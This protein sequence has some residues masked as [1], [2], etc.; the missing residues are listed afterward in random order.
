MQKRLQARARAVNIWLMAPLLGFAVFLAVFM[1]AMAPV[2]AASS[3]Y[4]NFQAR[5]LGSNGTIVPD[6]TYNIDFKLYNADSTTGTVGTCSGTC[7]W[8]ETRKNSNSQ[9]VQVINGY[10][11]VNLGSVTAFPS[12]INWDQQLWLTMNIGGTSTGASPT[13]DGEMQN[14]GHSILLTAI[15]YSFIAGQLAKTSGANRGTLAF[16]TV[17]NN[18][19]ILLPDASGTVCLQSASACGFESTT[20]TDFIRNQVTVQTANFNI[21]GTGIIGTAL[22]TGLIKTA[23]SSTASTNDITLR[24]GNQTGSSLSSGN[25]TIKSGDASGGTNSSS[26]N[27]TID[28]GAK[29]G[30][31]TTGTISIGASNASGITIGNISL[32]NT[33]AIDASTISIGNSTSTHTINIGHGGTS[34]Q[35]INIGSTSSGSGVSI[36][37]GT[38]GISLSGNTAVSGNLDVSGSFA[39]KK[40]AADY[41]T[42]GPQ[43]DVSFGNASLVRLT[44][45]ST[46]TI[47]GIANGRDG[48]LLNLV[49]AA[50]QTAIIKN[51]DTT[52]SAAANVV[53]TG[54]G[55]DYNLLAG[56]STQLVYDAG[57]NVWRMVGAAVG[58]TGLGTYSSS[59]HYAN[60]AQISGNTLT[61]GSADG[62]N[63]GL[64]DTSNQTFAGN[65][66]FSGTLTVA[67][68]TNITSAVIKQTSAASPTADV[69]DVVGINGTSNFIQVTSTAANQGAVNIQ[70]FGA[71]NGL[72]IQ[73]GSGTVSLGTSTTLNAAAGL[74]ITSGGT[75]DLAL[76][77]LSG[78]LKFG[79][80]T[81]NLLFTTAN[82]AFVDAASTKTLNLGTSNDGHLTRVG[83]S[84]AS[85]TTTIQG[86]NGITLSGNTTVS[87]G[88]T[89]TVTDGAA[90]LTDSTG[91]ALT[92]NNSTGANSI[93]IFQDNGTAVT[94]IA[95]NGQITFKNAGDTASAF[96]IQNNGGSDLLNVNTSDGYV[97]N[98]GTTDISNVLQNPGFEASGSGDGTGWYTPGAGQAIT[99]DSVN[100]HGGNRELQVT[101]NSSTHA[102]STK[103]YAVHPGDTIYVEAYVKNSAGATGDAGIY[104]EFSDKDKGNATFTTMDT[105]LPGTSYVLKSSTLTVPA[106]K[107]YVRV[108]ASVRATAT[109][110]TFYFDDFYLKRVNEQA[111]L[112]LSGISST[113]FQ[114]QNSSS[115]TV[116]GVD[117]S[118]SRIFTTIPDGA[119]AVGFTFNTPN[120]T[121]AGAKLLSLQN[122]LAEKFSVDKD[123]NVSAAGNIA[124]GGNLSASGNVNIGSGKQYQIGGTQVTS[125]ILSNDNN[126]AKLSGTGPQVFSGNNE[127]D[128][129]VL[130][131][132]ASATAFQVQNASNAV[133]TVDTSGNRVILGT[134]SAVTGA[135]QF[136][137]SGGA[138]KLY[139]VGPTTPDAGNWTL[140]IPTITANDTICTNTTQATACTNYASASGLT[141]GL[142]TKLNKNSADT[143]AS[144]VTAVQGNLYAFTN[145]SNTVASGILKLDNGNNTGN[146]LTVTGSNNY[147]TGNAYV[148]INNTNAAPSGL[149]LDIQANG[150]TKFNVDAAGNVTAAGN[151]SIAS[152]KQ[153][154]I[155]GVQIS[156]AALSD[157]SSIAFT[158]AN[159]T[160]SGNNTFSSS[161]NSFTGS[162]AG[163]TSLN[164]SNVSSGTLNDG[165]L[166]TN[167]ALLNRTGQTFSGDNTFAPSA[168]N[169]G[170]TI[171]QTSNATATSGSILDVQTQDGTGHF[172]Q[173]TNA[174]VNQGAVTL[175]SV[176]AGS[177]LTLGSASGTM[178]IT[179]VTNTIQHNNSSLTIDLNNGTA[180]TL[181][182]T[183]S[184]SGVTANLDVEGNAN[185]GAGMQYK[186]GG[187]QISSA[188]LSNDSDLA[189]RGSSN[190]FTATNT[191]AVTSTTAFQ[192]QNGGNAAVLIVD[193]SNRQLK[194]MENAGSTNYA[195]IYYDSS[196]ST[197]NYTANTGTV[198]VGTGAGAITVTAGSGSAVNITANA[199]SNWKTNSGTLTLQS[200]SGTSD[201]LILNSG[202]SGQVQVSGSSVIK[203]GSATAD[204]TCNNGAIYYNSSTNLFRGCQ[205]GA[206]ANLGTITPTLQ[207]TYTASTGGTTPEVKA[208]S[209]RGGIDIQDAD[210]GINSG[211][212][213][214]LLAVRMQNAAGL[215]SSIFNV[216]SANNSVNIGSSSGHSTN[217]VILVLDNYSNSGADPTGVVGAM[218]YNGTNGKFRCYDGTW[219]DCMT[220]FNEITKTSDQAVSPTNSIAFNNDNTLVF[221]MAANT[222]YVI[223]GWIP[224]DDTTVIGKYTFTA[225][226][227][228]VMNISTSNTA[229]FNSSSTTANNICNIST[230]GT[231]CALTVNNAANFIQV[232][233]FIRNG[234][235]AGNLQFQFG[236]NS[237]NAAAF[238]VIKAG[239]VLTWR[240]AN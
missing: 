18:P 66:T 174:A 230:S 102:I 25:V 56:S 135:I 206:W 212:G 45:A 183:N 214:I 169:A 175:Q 172:L 7:L 150:A 19:N 154:Q 187:T 237:A 153:Y 121:T 96:Q 131:K 41:S 58:V 146:V 198:A 98:N 176:G 184:Q 100:A 228:A 133:F 17:A 93:A 151:V 130:N 39:L 158:S 213:G 33:A 107:Y 68:A 104:V 178:S 105:G 156:T 40:A 224:I 95:D 171:R 52:D 38:A 108:A 159:Q 161:S 189:K 85:A 16:N 132:V 27:V 22:Q 200:G 70:S 126:L 99:T 117:S 157:G 114:V 125:A 94:T 82:Q 124:S 208:D 123:G 143:S 67:P 167:V 116:L 50:G 71:A 42:V 192:V 238:P 89:F 240:T 31:G 138:G 65:K 164:A 2:Q 207:S 84:N 148:V 235:T 119:S 55:A 48:Y 179:A 227:G 28:V 35:I 51:N 36:S 110:G 34:T 21:D 120:Y 226:T 24:S 46:Q 210:G 231:T 160:F 162:G 147:G 144:S 75:S 10:F 203:L 194:V 115:Q 197:A 173:I 155:G 30:S 223:D 142:N 216:S 32:T 81:T 12:T 139:L 220:G 72:T 61:L 168:A 199:A 60:G 14:N 86:G 215:G 77:S 234:S 193:T 4:L 3:S 152:G 5:L 218:Y 97:I 111:P 15:P 78:T 80:N 49:N 13:W 79:T 1:S 195:L 236:Q 188:N 74:T 229:T 191:V 101:G 53:I 204:P 103:Y 87:S 225:P 9:G 149:M 127:F 43:N 233:G 209:T 47:T 23:D 59:N 64:V 232:R 92:V 109:A 118:N 69:F 165:R 141:S 180:S 20:G 202:G 137:G 222:N 112:L 8:E 134:A 145:N 62:S 221:A 91:T 205:N 182:V 29:S 166:S 88:K 181:F 219:R 201:F 136:Q 239:A 6:G 83:S 113:E 217:P 177:A 185:I 129:T 170:T 26:G 106:S 186:V 122:N 90:S 57:A 76:D 163:L 63:P 190:T 140:T 54:T 11:S 211:A 73:S 196:T 37:A 128:G 44:G